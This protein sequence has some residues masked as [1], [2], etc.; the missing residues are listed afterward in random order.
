MRLGRKL[1]GLYPDAT[2]SLRLSY[3]KVSGWT[4]QGQATPAFT[5][6]AGM[7]DRATGAEPF[8]LTPD[9]WDRARKGKLD[10]GDGARL[11]HHQRHHRRQFRLAG[12]Q[13][14]G[15]GD[16]RGVRRQHPLDRRSD[17]TYD[18]ALNRTIAVSTVAI[19]EA[20]ERVYGDTAL[21]HELAGDNQPRSYA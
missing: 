6:F 9:R 10:P 19:S 13:R 5:T 3:G 8:R 20:L 12:R 7:F 11:R 2:F 4:D 14:S 16:R 21:A 15:R 18:A 17:F 1:P